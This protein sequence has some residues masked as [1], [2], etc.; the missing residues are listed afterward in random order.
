[1]VAIRENGDHPFKLVPLALFKSS[2][3]SKNFPMVH[4]EKFHGHTSYQ[5]FLWDIL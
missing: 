3:L 5:P 1:M 2:A 4:T